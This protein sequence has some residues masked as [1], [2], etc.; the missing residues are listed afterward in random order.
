[1]AGGPEKDK[2][3][4]LVAIVMD[5]DCGLEIMR[6]TRKAAGGDRLPPT[7]GP[8]QMPKFVATTR[9]HDQRRGVGTIS[10]EKI[11]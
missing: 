11:A 5:S 6:E 3:N 1:M 2:V 9:A 4:P 8:E 7:K 10:R